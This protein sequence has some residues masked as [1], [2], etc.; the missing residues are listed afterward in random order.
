MDGREGRHNEADGA[1]DSRDR[2]HDAQGADGPESGRER[3]GLSAI[4][5][6][7]FAGSGAH[8][9]RPCGSSLHQDG[10]LEHIAR[11]PRHHDLLS[12]WGPR[13]PFSRPEEKKTLKRYATQ[14]P[15]REDPE[16]SGSWAHIDAGKTT[17]TE[18]DPLLHR[19]HVQDR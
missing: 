13:A 15:T 9:R 7:R 19:S 4:V 2:K 5:A 16:Q 17:T 12:A 11:R 14:I 6:L 3:E 18:P 1:R 8:A 10:D